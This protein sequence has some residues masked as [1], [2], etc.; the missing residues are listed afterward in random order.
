MAVLSVVLALLV[1]VLF[2]LIGC[3]FGSTVMN[4]CILIVLFSVIIGL[5][6]MLFHVLIIDKQQRNDQINK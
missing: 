2:L 1:I 4:V 3:Y 5:L 6:S